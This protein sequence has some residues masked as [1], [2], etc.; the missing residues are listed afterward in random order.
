VQQGIPVVGVTETIQPPDASFQQWQLGELNDL[1]NALNA[2]GL[3]K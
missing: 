3:V 1:Q 2:A